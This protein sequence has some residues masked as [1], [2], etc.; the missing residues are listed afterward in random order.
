LGGG[1]RGEKGTGRL[2]KGGELVGGKNSP[3]DPRGK[4]EAELSFG[5]GGKGQVR[6]KNRKE[7]LVP[8]QKKAADGLVQGVEW[9]GYLD[10]AEKGKGCRYFRGGT[11]HTTGEK[12]IEVKLNKMKMSSK[13][14]S[15]SGGGTKNKRSKNHVS[16]GREGMARGKRPPGGGGGIGNFPETQRGGGGGFYPKRREEGM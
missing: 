9:G 4:W 12:E 1:K 13:E 7:G 15:G 10:S 2:K 16:R 5:M 3:P 11:Q 6:E 14:R 8:P